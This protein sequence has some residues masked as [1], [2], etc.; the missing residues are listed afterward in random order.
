MSYMKNILTTLAAELPV[1]PRRH[2]AAVRHRMVLEEV[3]R[4]VLIVSS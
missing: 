1:V 3:A 4:R 2:R